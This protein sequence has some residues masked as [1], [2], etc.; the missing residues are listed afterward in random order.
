MD[1]KSHKISQIIKTRQANTHMIAREVAKGFKP[2]WYAVIHFNDGASST[3]Q[4]KRRIRPEDVEKDLLVVKHQLYTELYGARWSKKHKRA[5]SIWGV[6]YGAS[7]IKPH[8]NIIMEELPFPY[9]H[10]KSAFI[11]FNSYLPAKC[12][13]LWKHSTH[14][15]PVE[16]E[17][18]YLLNSYVCKESN[19]DNCTIIH[20]LTDYQL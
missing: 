16:T 8:V 3:K 15:Q 18:I 10:Y 17:S 19:I 12:K 2:R 13:C 20:K 1:T 5:K 14:L 9:D 7:Q 11:L 4:Q 6:E